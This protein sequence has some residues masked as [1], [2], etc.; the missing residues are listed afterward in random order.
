VPVG[1][2]GRLPADLV[3]RYLAAHGG[4]PGPS[5]PARED[6]EPSAARA[7]LEPRTPATP[8]PR[9]SSDDGVVIAR[10][11]SAKPRWDWNR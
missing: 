7:T 5:A 1:E 3:A 9:T 6:R 10:T 2:R 8:K 4:R 11:V